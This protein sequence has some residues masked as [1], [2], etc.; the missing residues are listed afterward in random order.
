MYVNLPLYS[1]K[2]RADAAATRHP[3]KAKVTT[4]FIS[5]TSF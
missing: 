3:T 1:F 4:Y 5:P 2:L